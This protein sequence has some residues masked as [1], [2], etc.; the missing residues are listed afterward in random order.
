MTIDSW[1]LQMIAKF[2][3]EFIRNVLAMSQIKTAFVEHFVW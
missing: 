3:T 2:L 1:S